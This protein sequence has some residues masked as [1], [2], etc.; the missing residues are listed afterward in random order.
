MDIELVTIGTELLLGF[1]IDTNA[2]ELA[3]AL[4][5]VGARVVRR[6]TVGDEGPAIDDAIRA[7]LGRTRFVIATGG[8]GPTK[9]DITKKVAAA[10]FDTPL[11]LDTGYLEALRQRFADLGRIPMPESN[12]S[13][14]EIPRGA[15]VLPNR[16]GT[17]P[18]LW[19]EGK[20]GIA[21]LLPGVP[22]EM[23]MLVE[24]EVIP[25]IERAAQA[26]THAAHDGDRRVGAG[27]PDRGPGRSPRAGD[28]GVHPVRRRSGPPTH[29]IRAHG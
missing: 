6:T 9:D 27:G 16:W 24:H 17:A 4:A 11:E 19:L 1:T 26:I 20:L 23:R 7:A 15:T 28:A 14:A 3:R 10:I 21:V 13:Q 25:R 5:S 2:A 12:R 22:R 8:L 18:G 29:G